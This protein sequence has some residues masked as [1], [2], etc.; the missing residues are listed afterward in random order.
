MRVNVSV[1]RDDDIPFLSRRGG[2]LLQRLQECGELGDALLLLLPL[3]FVFLRQLSV[4][5][6]VFCRSRGVRL[7]KNSYDVSLRNPKSTLSISTFAS[8]LDGNGGAF[9]TAF[10][11][12]ECAFISIPQ[13]LL[14]ANRGIDFLPRL[15]ELVRHFSVIRM[16]FGSRIYKI[17]RMFRIRCIF[18]R[19]CLCG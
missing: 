19:W 9:F 18:L 4:F 13:L 16:A 8:G 12:G 11:L 6:S 5:V 3:R 2:F 14:Y 15:S 17:S 10:G 1:L 7:G